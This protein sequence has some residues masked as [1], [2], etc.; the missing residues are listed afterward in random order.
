MTMFKLLRY[1]FYL[2]RNPLPSAMILFLSPLVSLSICVFLLTDKILF[3]RI[4]TTFDGVL[5]AKVVVALLIA[6]FFLI[7]LNFAM[8][9]CVSLLTGRVSMQIKE[10][11]TAELLEYDYGFF[12]THDSGYIVKRLVEDS[13]LIAEGIVKAY[14]SISHLLNIVA[15]GIIYYCFGWGIFSLYCLTAAVQITWALLLKIPIAKTGD[16]TGMGYSRM[17]DFFWETLPGIREIKLQG[18]QG[19]VMERLHELDADIAS[20]LWWNTVYNTLLWA[21][22]TPLSYWFFLIVMLTGLKKVQ[23]GQSST[24]IFVLLLGLVQVTLDPLRQF[25][26]SIGGMHR[27]RSAVKRIESLKGDFKEPS[28]KTVLREFSDRIL[29]KEASLRFESGRN[30]LNGVD[31]EIPKYSYVAIVGETGS[32]KSTIAHVMV[33]LYRNYIGEVTVDGKDLACLETAS[34]RDRVTLVTQDIFLFRKSIRENIDPLGAL[35]DLQIREICRVAQLEDFLGNL[36]HGLDTQIGEDG[37]DFSGGER[38]RISIARCLAKESDVII[39]DEATSA[40]DPRTQEKLMAGLAAF[41]SGKTII[42]ITHNAKIAE[43]ASCIFV[44]EDGRLAEFGSHSG[45]IAKK[46]VYHRLFNSRNNSTN[47]EQLGS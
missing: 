31:M 2:V 1:A 25:M 47:V 20:N 41:L 37:I 27:A 23:E 43:Q 15:S 4:I 28:G 30:A 16:N 21:L 36:P 39:L 46:G 35:T 6:T 18:I 34:L 29:L 3:D 8:N 11:L 44:M 12:L 38:Q 40:L 10:D 13:D 22:I 42:S 14:N 45:L 17:Y 32:G 9:L 5:M 7:A 19:Y 26:E 33:K 24:G